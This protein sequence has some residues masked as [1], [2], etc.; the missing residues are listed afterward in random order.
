MQ[1]PEFMMYDTLTVHVVEGA[2]SSNCV[3]SKF[4]FNL[5]PRGH[6]T[7]LQGRSTIHDCKDVNMTVINKA[8]QMICT[9]SVLSFTGK[10]PWLFTGQEKIKTFIILSIP[11]NI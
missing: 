1:G 7:P 5:D 11:S 8:P 2:L 6:L 10:T 9:V 3:R 4:V